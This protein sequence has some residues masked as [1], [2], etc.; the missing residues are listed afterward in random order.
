MNP[1][2]ASILA[3]LF[4][5]MGAVTV[6]IMLEMTGRARDHSGKSLWIR[7]HKI[8]G[9]LFLSLFVVMLFVMIRKLSGFQ[10]ELTSRAVI[11]IALALLLVP[12]L[13]V[14]ILMARR[15]SRLN[16]RLPLVGITIFTLSFALTG[17]TAGYYVLHRSNLTYTTLS[18]LDN[19]VLDA[20]L[21][22]SIVS[23]KCSKCHSLERV[24]RAFKS[25]ESWAKTIN[26]MA[27]LDSPNITSFDVKQVLNY[28]RVQQRN[29]QEKAN[30]DPGRTIGKTL[31]TQKCSICHNLDRV[32]GASKNS[33]EW[34]TTVGRMVATMDDPDFLSDQ[35]KVN[36][37]T[38]LSMREEKE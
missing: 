8:L 30:L 35:E 38:F 10:E 19:D 27:L 33:E 21:G 37:I 25:D 5:I 18:A 15:H 23:K 16:S 22:K 24:Y 13:V 17:L 2:I 1:K 12:L 3:A 32:F 4:I 29:R 9:Y 28:L 26:K 36:I 7:T 14:K 34:T 6:L 31:V 11:H 20:D